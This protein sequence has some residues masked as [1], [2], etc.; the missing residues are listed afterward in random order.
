MS[1]ANFR[2]RLVV[3]HENPDLDAIGFVYSVWKR[4]GWG[5][6]LEFKSPGKVELELLTDPSVIVGDVGLPDCCL[7]NNPDLNNF[8]HHYGCAD[9]CATHLFNVKFPVLREDVT[10]YIDDVDWG[11]GREEAGVNLNTVIIG[12]RVVHAG[13]DRKVVEEG[14]EILK[15]VEERGLSPR[16]LSELGAVERFKIYVEAG[17]AELQRIQR[18]LSGISIFTT[19]GGRIAGYVETSSDI[20]SLVGDAAFAG[21][22]ELDVIIIHNPSRGR[23]SIRSNTIREGWPR[24]V[25]ELT[26]A[27]SEAERE[28]GAPPQQKWGGREDRI[29]S[30]KPRSQLT[31]SEVIEFVRSRL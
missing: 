18:E 10:A 12:V 15:Y 24:L 22:P 26:E 19:R 11:R 25:G 6:P 16:D 8:D 14:C 20:F 1:F 23:Y 13:D 21:K 3:T 4:F 30:P 5:I 28:R 7:G 29:G 31:P 17:L 27:L 2:P 9:R